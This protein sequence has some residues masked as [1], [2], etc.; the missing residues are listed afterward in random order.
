MWCGLS[1]GIALNLSLVGLAQADDAALLAAQAV[2]TLENGRLLEI[3]PQS[4]SQ[5]K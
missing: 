4:S 5:R 2:A 1:F 3:C